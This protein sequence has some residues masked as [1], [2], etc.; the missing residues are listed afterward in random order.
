MKK[1]IKDLTADEGRKICNERWLGDITRAKKCE[2]CP[3]N[4]FGT[5][6]HSDIHIPCYLDFIE[7]IENKDADD[8]IEVE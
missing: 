1:K 6:S 7:S 4:F 8:E 3:L 2:D 5:E